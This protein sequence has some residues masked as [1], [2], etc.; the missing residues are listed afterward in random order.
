MT[1]K[2]LELPLGDKVVITLDSAPGFLTTGASDTISR[3]SSGMG[4]RVIWGTWRAPD[5]VLQ[6]GF[7][8]SSHMSYSWDFIRCRLG[9]WDLTAEEG[10]DSSSRGGRCTV[11]CHIK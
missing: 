9:T 2:S 8:T 4:L 3:G 7:G 10:R 11:L 1:R 5:K 6:E